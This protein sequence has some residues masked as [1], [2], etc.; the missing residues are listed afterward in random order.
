MLLGTSDLGSL[1]RGGREAERAGRR[2][3]DGDGIGCDVWTALGDDAWAAMG[4]VA[5]HYTVL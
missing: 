5:L 1:A 2:H 4:R 3:S